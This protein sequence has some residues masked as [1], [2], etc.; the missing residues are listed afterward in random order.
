MGATRAS[1]RWWA[2]LMVTVGI[3]I[4]G[5]GALAQQTYQ[6]TSTADDGS[7][8]TLR[9]AVTQANAAGSGIVQ[10]N[11]SGTITLASALPEIAFHGSITGSSGTVIDG[12]NQYRPFLVDLSS[13]TSALT[14]SNLTIE[15]GLARGG[16]GGS[17]SNQG[18][19]GGLGAGGAI[20]VNSGSLTL[21]NVTAQNSSA[22]GGQGG[23]GN[24]S[25]QQGSAGGGG[26]QGNGGNGSLGA[27]GGGGLFGNGGSGFYIAGNVDPSGGGGGGQY[28]DGGNAFIGTG[29]GGGGSA[30][31]GGSGSFF[32]TGSA[33]G[34][35][36]GGSGGASFGAGNSGSS[37]GGG[38][39]SADG[40]GGNG[41]IYGGGGGAGGTS[42]GG[43]GGDFGGGGGGQPG[44]SGGNGGFGGGAGGGY[45]GGA[46]GFGGG[47]GGNFEFNGDPGSFGGAGTWADNVNGFANEAAGGGGAALGG[48]IFVR[49]SNGASLIIQDSNI[50]S[51]SLTGGS[52]GT[53]HYTSEF[54]P[55][56]NASSGQTAGS[57]MFLYG[58]AT[59]I[60]VSS[61][62]GSQTISGTIVDG[63]ANP[64]RISKSGSGTLILTGTNTYTGGTTVAEGTLQIGIGGTNGSIT[65]DAGNLATLVFDR[66]DTYTFAG[67]VTGIAG[68][69]KQAGTGTLIATGA[70]ANSVVVSSGTLIVTGTVSNSATIAA[71]TLQIGNGGTTGSITGS[72]GGPGSLVFDR[73]DNLTFGNVFPGGGS[74]TQAGAG[75]ITLTAA[76]TYNGS[77][78]INGGTLRL[79]GPGLVPSGYA[80]FYSFDNVSGSTVI[81]GGS[82]ASTYNATFNGDAGISGG[83][84]QGNALW[85]VDPNAMLIPKTAIPI[86]LGSGGFPVATE[87]AWFNGL[88][89]SALA[90]YLF[91]STNGDSD[92][93]LTSGSGYTLA[94]STNGG[95]HSTGINLSA[96]A[97]GWHQLTVVQDFGPFNTTFYIDG[98]LLATI[99]DS[100]S[101][102]SFNAFGNIV[103]GQSFA[104]FMDDVYVYNNQALT[105]AQVQQLYYSAFAGSLPT[106]TAVQI[107]A[108]ATLDLGGN[109]QSF[110]SLSG[111][112]G[113]KVLLES[114]NLTVGS[115][116]TS[117]TFSGAISGT[118]SLIKSGAGTLTLAGAN[119]YTGGTTI[120]AGTL[121]IGAASALPTGKIVVGNGVSTAAL[122]LGHSIGAVTLSNSKLTINSKGIADVNNNTLVLNYSG[123]SPAGA[124]R[125]LLVSGF[126]SGNWNGAGINSSAAAA[127]ASHLT[128]LGY[129]DTGSSILIKYTYYGDNN[130]DGKVDVNDFKMFLDGLVATS[131]SS[132]SQGDYTYDGKVDIGNDF[133][134]FLVS[135]LKQSGALGDLAPIVEA[136]DQLTTTQKSQL[137]V[138]VPEPSLMLA[139]VFAAILLRPRRREPIEA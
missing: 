52:P 101:S 137:L 118:G 132:W 49:G 128:A 88:N 87:S 58:G 39:G 32:G 113:S 46:G 66:S 81:N 138:F 103:G 24:A 80:V 37:G 127:D 13:S 91:G 110:G 72:I 11:T 54:P 97:T 106:G 115:N 116:N 1:N 10:I 6:V 69:F 100:F 29:G 73:S 82:G 64:G 25:Q 68:T 117:T 27:G 105:A 109:N 23:D 59:A 134:L 35:G 21:A 62:L 12:N 89:T 76:N 26:L 135:Y 102:N 65:G 99:A 131:G 48:A 28:Y 133:N 9:W 47:G 7:S 20:F 30:G 78:T 108:A 5:A 61:T 36:G 34:A 63:G 22:V 60:S 92:A 79:A 16:S 96:Y 93:L 104:Q 3:A 56:S 42:N 139:P 85:F 98:K 33:G 2:A 136:D 120:T 70:I 112:A 44:G 38:G 95:V 50:D 77:T 111:A 19:G 8:G 31:P 17:S 119:T 122:Q 4:T 124:I 71:G 57:Y 90:R 53:D 18:G 14:I 74:L 126:N 45:F 125:A 51:G 55:F 83:G 130:L 84:I 94:D 107:G 129:K 75:T 123:A 86:L 15:N 41:G 43:N 114:G 67:N 40:N 121:A